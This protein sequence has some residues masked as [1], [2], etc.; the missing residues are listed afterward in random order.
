MTF[1]LKNWYLFSPIRAS[2]RGRT[3]YKKQGIREKLN[4]FSHQKHVHGKCISWLDVTSYL[5]L[6][7]NLTFYSLKKS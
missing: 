6:V 1:Q 3:V 4:K 5:P 7:K 2:I